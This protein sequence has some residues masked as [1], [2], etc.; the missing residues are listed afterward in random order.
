MPAVT[1][2]YVDSLPP[3]YRDILAAFPE[4]EPGMKPGWGLAYQTLAARLDDK[5]SRGETAQAYSVGEIM[6]ACEN[7]QE[8]GAF[9]IKSRIFVH[10]S[11]LSESGN[12]IKKPSP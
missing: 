4:I 1:K 6:Q 10:T 8:G 5:H 11:P 2:E 7:M 3:I 12:K 9:D